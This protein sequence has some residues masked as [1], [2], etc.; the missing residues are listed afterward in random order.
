LEEF[1]KES[2]S[3]SEEEDEEEE[4]QSND[5][6]DAASN[7]SGEE[8][9]EEEESPINKNIVEI[10]TRSLRNGKELTQ[11]QSK[12]P[13]SEKKQ[14]AKKSDKSPE[15]RVGTRSAHRLTKSPLR[16]IPMYSLK[17]LHLKRRL[18]KKIKSKDKNKDKKDASK[19]DSKN[20]DKKESKSATP[21][22][23]EKYVI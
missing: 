19:K 12:S 8:S 3:A 16:E 15:R 20:V 5:P 1:V 11:P 23:T 22:K 13:I 2:E 14:T 21:K 9:E 18:G 6:S 10:A 4:G 17:P 7:E